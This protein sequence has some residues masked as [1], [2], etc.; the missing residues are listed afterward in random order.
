MCEDVCE[1][2]GNLDVDLGPSEL[3]FSNMDLEATETW[4]KKREREI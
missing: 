4:E 1:P 2:A 3:E